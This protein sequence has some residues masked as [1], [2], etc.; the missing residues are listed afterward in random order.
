MTIT[1]SSTL[2]RAAFGAAI[3]ACA[4]LFASCPTPSGLKYCATGAPCPAGTVCAGNYCRPTT[5]DTQACTENEVCNQKG[6]CIPTECADVKCTKAGQI[7][8]KGGKCVATACVTGSKTCADGTVCDPMTSNCIEPSCFLVLCAG[9]EVCSGGNCIFTGCGPAN[10]PC[11]AGE[12]CGD[13][14]TCQDVQCIYRSCPDGKSCSAGA[15][16]DCAETGCPCGAVTCAAGEACFSG[17]C[18]PVSCAGVACRSGEICAK[19]GKTCITSDC[20]AVSCSSGQVCVKGKCESSTC[21]SSTCVQGQSCQS[22]SCVDVLCVGKSCASGEQ[23]AGGRCLPTTCSGSASACPSGQL[24]DSGACVDTRCVAAVCPSGKTCSAG[25]CVSISCA[26]VACRSGEICGKD[27][28]TCVTLDC[29]PVSCSS[30]Q[31]CVKGKCE[32]ATCGAATCVQG[33]SCQSGTCTDVLCLG[34]TCGA[35]EQCAAGRCLPTTCPGSPSACPAGQL[36]DA[37]RCADIRCLGAV[38]AAG[39]ACAAGVCVSTSC[40]SVPCRSGE[41]CGKDG[42]TCVTPECAFTSCASDQICVAGTCESSTCGSTTCVQGQACRGD[43]CVDGRCAAVTCP[44]LQLCVA[45]TCHTTY[46]GPAYEPCPD[47]TVCDQDKCTE[48]RCVGV[49]CPSGKACVAGLCQ[50]GS[51]CPA[52]GCPNGQTCL[53]GACRDSSCPGAA[54]RLDQYCVDGACVTAACAGVS[55]PAD[56]ICVGGDCVSASCGA[57]TCAAGQVC[58]QASETCVD[59]ICEQVGCAPGEICLGGQCVTEDCPGV[60]CPAGEACI[61]GRCQDTRC[62]GVF[63]PAG[64]YCSAGSCDNACAATETACG[65]GI[66]EDCDGL[67]DC[68]DSDCDAQACNDGDACTS[69]DSCSGGLCIGPTVKTC[70]APA[71]D[72]HVGSGQCKPATGKCEYATRSAGATCVPTAAPAA[73]NDYRCNGAA[74]CTGTASPTDTE[75]GTGKVCNASG[76]CVADGGAQCTISGATYAAGKVNPANPC[77]FCSP[78]A[79]ATAWTPR[80]SGLSCSGGACD[81]AGTCRQGCVIG[82]VFYAPGAADPSSPCRSCEVAKNPS[83]WT[84][85]ATA[86]SCG[87]GKMCDPLGTCVAGCNIGGKVRLDGQV[88]P[89]N[90]C[91]VCLAATST[92]AWSPAADGKSCAQGKVCQANTCKDGCWI[93]G[94]FVAPSAVSPDDE[95]QACLPAQTATA[96]SRNDGAACSEGKC[97]NGKCLGGCVITTVA[98]SGVTVVEVKTKYADGANNPNNECQKCDVYANAREWTDKADGTECSGGKTCLGGGCGEGCVVGDKS[99]GPGEKNATNA[100]LYCD[101]AQSRSKLSEMPDQEVCGW[102]K[103]CYQKLCTAVCLIDG[104]PFPEKSTF[105]DD[106]TTPNVDESDTCRQCDPTR[107]F[108]DWSG[109]KAHSVCW[110]EWGG[111]DPDG[112]MC[113]LGCIEKETPAAP[114]EYYENAEVNP[115]ETCQIC[116]INYS[117][118]HWKPRNIAA[119]CDQQYKVCNNDG[120]CSFGCGIGGHYFLPDEIN[121]WNKCQICRNYQATHSWNYLPSGTICGDNEGVCASNS[122]QNGCWIGGGYT[123][124]GGTAAGSGNGA[125]QKCVTSKSRTGWQLNGGATCGDKQKCSTKTATC[126]PKDASDC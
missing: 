124:D 25:V 58:D 71:D 50:T 98:R 51:G 3:V 123:R 23:C 64:K 38:C 72:C 18:A 111:D 104:L 40:G 33:Q 91:E 54:C 106:L 115:K 126:C 32:S 99:Y 59:S 31:V 97:I 117:N 113:R 14:G 114:L 107:N 29:A 86:S 103:M 62:L 66:D 4:A 48:V 12:A 28:K 34:K 82:S 108:F 77:Q 24:C 53:A 61:G 96:Y 44:L 39:Q 56:Q 67:V 15:C 57:A 49:T 43:A 41:V 13:D 10:G 74:V 109:C 119:D 8:A 68:A 35:G 7:C 125:C 118:W 95:C 102:G 9:D 5:C 65:D 78:T 1:C 6:E 55:C 88:N 26:S 70:P 101:P 112:R 20:A 94:A 21:G 52:D 60:H 16:V 116:D 36:C 79:S 89:E 84:L 87:A 37:G 121:Y 27:G 90:P 85:K 110:E 19:D 80:A 11:P 93:D 17:S 83:D 45:G 92:T 69:N 30:G 100:C 105:P 75:C 76:T 73:C 22:G 122:C 47:G 46:C 120:H 42:K 63:C 2:R 81:A